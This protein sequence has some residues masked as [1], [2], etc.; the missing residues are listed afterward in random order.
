M[1]IEAIDTAKSL[2][3]RFDATVHLAHVHQFYYP[4]GFSAAMPPV[5][6]YSTWTYDEE[7]EK[8]VAGELHLLAKK[9]QLSP[10]A[11]HLLTGAPAFD[12]ISRLA[13]DL[14]ADLIVMPTHGRTG[15]KRVFLGS[16]AERVVQH[17]PCPVLIIRKPTKRASN[18][19][20]QRINTILVPVDFS[21]CSAEGLR[22]AIWFAAKF[23]AK[24]VV[25]HV[26][27]LGIAYTADGYAMYD[28]SEPIK[29]ARDDAARQM[30][31]FV[32]GLKFGGVKF[33]TA[34]SDG[35]A[36]DGICGFAESN[37]VDLIITSTH[38]RTGFDHVLMGSIAE[39]VVRRAPCS[40]LTVPSFARAALPRTR[41]TH[42]TDSRPGRSPAFTKS[43]C[44]PIETEKLTRKYRKITAHE[45]PQRRRTNRFRETHL[46]S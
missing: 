24:I 15:F 22:Y 2:A 45:F 17:S 41:R 23:A 19:T 9:H 1:S 11:A 31:Q 44:S 18:G 29:A 27:E 13:K 5:I 21:R 20:S 39:N 46:L 7:A 26:A 30:R 34:I 42:A 16:T 12:G 40:V 33:E 36:V 38:G 25:L 4:S 35:F 43:A 32:H 14:A 6:P 10:A 3:A 37:N 8:Y 28:L